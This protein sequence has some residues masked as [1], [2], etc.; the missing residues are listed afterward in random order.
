MVN[1]SPTTDMFQSQRAPETQ[2]RVKALDGLRGVAVLAVMLFHTDSSPLAGGF[3]GVDLFF[4]LSGFLITGILFR[5]WNERNHIAL[6]QFW[7]RRARR[8]APP[9]LVLISVV[10]LARLVALHGSSSEMR[11]EVLA[12][13]TYTT[14]WFEILTRRDYFAQFEEPSPLQHTWSLSI[15]EQFYL[16]L[17]AFMVV[18]LPRVASKQRLAVLF[19]GLSMGSAV[20][21]WQGA[22]FD[23]EEWAY[24]GTAPR[25]QAL[26]VGCVLAM[27]LPE[28]QKPRPSSRKTTALGCGALLVLVATMTG[29]PPC[30]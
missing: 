12:G 16:L 21:M 6:G 19:A 14:N 28:A 26:L 2:V 22:S 27:W 3:L 29:R 7:L 18:L 25:I 23:H 15:E 17:A 5:Q 10:T 9:L 20:L 1:R 8:L 11:A 30:P 4:V 13:L 24:Y